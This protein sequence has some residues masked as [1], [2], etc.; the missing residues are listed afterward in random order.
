MKLNILIFSLIFSGL[1]HANIS[2]ND[3]KAIAKYYVYNPHKTKASFEKERKELENKIV[4]N[5]TEQVATINEIGIIVNGI[6]EHA[7]PKSLTYRYYDLNCDLRELGIKLVT[8]NATN[9]KYANKASE[10]LGVIQI[11]KA[12]EECEPEGY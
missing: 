2:V 6:G 5:N 4:K 7:V 9:P 8:L 3:E 12:F 10:K 11:N 1:A